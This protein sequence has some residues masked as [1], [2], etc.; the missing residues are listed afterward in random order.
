MT[1]LGKSCWIGR[2]SVRLLMAALLALGGFAGAG[3]QGV[4]APVSNRVNI[5]LGETPWRY[6]KDVDPQN[7]MAPAFDDSRWA[8]VGVPQSPSDQ[9]TFLN[10][11]AGGNEGQLTGNLNWYRKHFKLAPDY[12]NRKIFVEFEGAHV[13]AQVYING[14]FVP[15]NSTVNPN[16]THVIGFVPFVVDITDSVKFDGSDN[17]L[18][19]KVARGDKFFKSPGFSGAFRFGQSDAGLFRPVRMHITDRVHIPQNVYSVLN[20]WGT[21]VATLSADAASATIKVRTNV[22]NEYAGDQ[23]VTLTTQ[24]VD[25][26]GNVVATAQESRVAPANVLPGLHPIAFDQ[27]L[28]VAYP[29][30]WYPNNSVYGK[31]YL[32]HVLHSVSI[33]GNVVDAVSTPL[34]IRTIS[35]DQNFP[36]INGHP[37][38]LWGASGRYDYPA[39]GSAMP[40]EQKWR[41]L[42]LL[43][44]AGGSLYRPGHSSEGPEFLNAA[45]A[46]GV[47]VIQPSGD[48]ENSF[49]ILCDA[50]ITTNCTSADNALLKQELH[51]DVIVNG[52]NNPSVLAWEADN[53]ATDTAFAQSLKALSHIWDPILPR[54]QSDRTPNPA[55]GDILGC[56]QQGCDILTKRAFPDVP[57]W[58]SEYWG[59]G[60]ARAAYDVELAFAAPY[61]KDWSNSVRAK[62]FGIA[63]WYLADTPGEIETQ[64]DGMAAT[65]VRGNAA[66]MMDGNREPRLLYYI[67]QAA[68]TPFDVKPVVKLGHHW[69]RAGMVRVNAFSNC[70]LV[71]LLINGQQQGAD[72]AP[73]AQDADPSAD[74]SQATT[75]LPAQAHW[76]VNWQPGTLTADCLDNF[77][78]VV[79]SD[80]LVTAGPADHLLLTVE[81]ELVKP[82]GNAFV[83]SANGSDAAFVTATVVD[84]NNNRVFDAKPVLTFSVS[85]PGTYRGGADHAVSAGQ[86]AGFHAPGDPNL[87]AE[88]GIAKVAVK[89]QFVPGTV[90]VSA[91]ADHLGDGSVTFDVQPLA[92]PAYYDGATLQVAAPA[93]SELQLVAQPIGQLVAV[94]QT[95]H[96]TA[97]VSGTGPLRFQWLKNQQP[98]AGANSYDYTTPVAQLGDNGASYSVQ[99]SN[100]VAGVTSGGATLT[101]MAPSAPSIVTQ[102]AAQSIASGQSAQFSVTAAG[103]PVLSYQ[104]LRNG[105]T[106]PG[107]TDSVT[108]TPAMQAADSGVVYS[109]VVSN[110]VGSVTSTGAVLTVGAPIAPSIINA[111]RS[112]KVSSGQGLSFSVLASGSAPLHYQWR[113]GAVAVGSDDA[114]YVIAAA[115]AK[116]AGDYTVIVSNAAGSVTSR[117]A[118]LDVSGGS[119]VNFA[120]GASATSSSRQN[121][122]SAANFAI[123]GDTSTRWAS[124]PGVDPSWIALDLGAVRTF[125]QVTLVWENAYGSAY[126]IQTSDDNA[127]WSTVYTQGVGHGGTETLHFPSVSARYVRML[128]T[129]RATA[130]GYSLFE[131]EVHDVPQCGAGERYALQGALSGEYSSTIPGIPSGPFV[132]TVK[133]NLSQLEWQQYVTTFQQQG[134][135]FT[136]PVAAQYCASVGMRLPTRAEAMTIAGANYAA[137]GFPTPWGSWTTTPVP[138]DPSSAYFAFSNGNTVAG[139]IVNTPGWALCVR[140]AAIAPPVISL[141]PA[142]QSA[143]QG[144]RAQWRV[145]VDGN[146]PFSYQWYKNGAPA[147]V[148]AS[149]LLITPPL[150]ADDNGAQYSVVISNGGGSVTSASATL[151]VTAPV[152]NSGGDANTPPPQP[153]APS[154]NLALGR[155]VSASGSQGDS[156]SAAAATDGNAGSRW[157]SA[158]ADPSWIAVDLGAVQTIDRV[159]LRWEAAYGVAYQ[160]QVSGDQKSWTPVYTQTSG[161]GGVE[162]IRFAAVNARYVRMY[163]TRR[164]SQYGYSLFEFEVYNT[165]ATPQYV[166]SAS[167]GAN[168]ALTPGGDTAIYQGGSQV[169]TV[170]PAPGFAVTG[171]TVDGKSLGIQSTYTFDNLQAPHRISATFGPQAASVN[172]ALGRPTDSSALE[173]DGHPASAAVDGKADTRWSS[174]HADPSWMSIDL[175]SPQTFNR[176]V[177][178][179]ENAYGAA[180]QI[181]VSDD[182][183]NWSTVYT[184][185][186]G[187]GGIEDFGFAPTTTRYIRLYGT[188]RS[189]QYGYSLYEFE[190]YDK[191]VPPAMI[192][193]P[194]DQRVNAGQDATFMIAASGTAPLHY[195][196]LKNGL[197]LAVTEAPAYTI[198]ST[199][200]ADDGAVISVVVSNGAGSVSSQAAKLTVITAPVAPG[201]QAGAGTAGAGANVN[202]AFGKRVTSSGVQDQG[203]HD[204]DAVDGNT[205]TRWSSAFI[206]PSWIAVDLGAS[207]SFDRVVLRWEAAYGAAYQIQASTDGQNWATLYAQDN[208]AG[209]TEDIALPMTTARFV[210]MYGTRRSSQY[211]Y[212]LLEFEIYNSTAT[213]HYTI[214]ASTGDHGAVSPTGSQVAQGAGQTFTF[215]P[216]TGY[217]VASLLVDGK[218][219]APRDRYTFDNVIAAHAIAATFAPVASTTNLALGRPAT[220]SGVE[221]G[222]TTAA[223]AV[224]GRSDTRWASTFTDPSWLAVDLGSELAF[225]RIS[226]QWEGAYATEYQIQTSHDNQTWAT[227]YSQVAGTGGLETC[228]FAQVTARYVRLYGSR[229]SSQ[230]GYSLYEFG[231]YNDG[232][233]AA[234]PPPVAI[235]TQPSTQ[236]VLLDQSAA[237]TIGTA[238]AGPYHYQWRKN[239]V[240][241]G[242]ATLAGYNTPPVTTSDDGA[243]YDVK[244]SDASGASATSNAAALIVRPAP[245]YTARPGVIG[246]DLQNNTKGA[247]RDDQV[248]VAVIARDPATGQFSWLKPDG[249]IV[250]ASAADN[251]AGGHLSKNGQNYSN[252]FFTLAQSKQLTLPKMDSGR[253]FVSLGGPMY[254][255]ILN[256]AN[257]NVGF[258]GP[259][260]LNP[261]DPNIDVNFDWYEFSYNNAGLW[262]NTTQVDQFS[263]PLLLDL[264]GSGNSVHAQ[265]GINQDRAALLSAFL[266]ETPPAFHPPPGAIRIPAPTN[267]SFGT[268]QAN[269]H[270][271]DA[272]IDQAWSYY[273]GHT[274]S[275]DVGARRFQGG[276]RGNQLVLTELNLNNGAYVGGD[277]LVS[278]PSTQ[279][280]LNGAGALANGNGTELAIEAQVCAAFNRHVMED[281]SQW[282]TPP[283][284]YGGA[285]ANAYAKFWHDH[286]VRGLAYGFP[287]DDVANQS[288]TIMAVQP[289]HLIF[290]IGW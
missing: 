51:R 164:S 255:K 86:P 285:P 257:G 214:A 33:A 225:N 12:A 276:V 7:A 282:N 142:D 198:A 72:V 63:H 166:I 216:A 2:R 174:A 236:T 261:T 88:G 19:V 97:L 175:G 167:S 6:I 109:V 61:L 11:E 38:Y 290:G 251:E 93:P 10:L 18:A 264:Y 30:L 45:D 78:H 35:W 92:S 248:Y 235:L 220:A 21:H 41:D 256:D 159:V 287:Y 249:T 169:Y 80:Q 151:T 241:I 117:V 160:I 126:Q 99:V 197:P 180:Y 50:A 128:G 74:T 238:G 280:V 89:T 161:V 266:A 258:A 145:M 52:R 219:I 28:T 127:S 34:G 222:D 131:F 123:D 134:A 232:D 239:G 101:V 77:G 100:Q 194:F 122:A 281:A 140:G 156:D 141:Q 211:G 68:W 218:A 135:Q 182:M 143:Q 24:I 65:M 263:F 188:Q 269:A 4:A 106:I 227:V 284:W 55:N 259:N 137:C 149:P 102:P 70:P 213:P 124:A 206:D 23:Q 162:D 146:G 118:T 105:V 71:R 17:V 67:Y 231:V 26:A 57:A 203:F 56:S 273:G 245:A 75:L 48:G 53:G 85:G 240:D 155:H 157:S 113:R 224:D 43:A 189:S 82:D 1:Q 202:L 95:A 116:D 177:L 148:T 3:A 81:P 150:G 196:W 171:L 271:F 242:G 13:G 115:Q 204:A 79:A 163:G 83:L 233:S 31:P 66:S 147:G 90:T 9:D 20:T 179:W 111:P 221:N 108:A 62:S 243:Q 207:L 54:A 274:L 58:G 125:N 138:N 193:P 210:R 254:I 279:D 49:A 191:P 200:A 87:S 212:S 132:P 60:A 27:T 283:A 234:T 208:G 96:F 288:S 176:V 103:S 120:V 230:Y 278:K 195:Q 39:L 114:S 237:F 183:L 42:R 37:H 152:N 136:Q 272:Y 201:G 144:D 44:N 139:I 5:N 133:D 91:H 244:V 110:G 76:D 36:I 260:V 168:G 64:V 270:Y 286:G 165:T 187:V 217:A 46:Y 98:I 47:M 185:T 252:Y 275:M 14:K 104:W 129:A 158:F 247:F 119:G 226:L 173:D 84:A 154:A 107:A 223:N 228:T 262:I 94:G 181:Q 32:Y 246:V 265:T 121:D 172:L 59:M 268:G 25:A 215:T 209:G 40:A 178:R 205:G 8:A 130:Y 73:N 199:T 253:V 69:N 16:A 184:Q 192:S 289:E 277:Y 267:G 153:S 112:Q 22:L 15:G 250:A 229:R 170:A 29:T 190:V 186:A